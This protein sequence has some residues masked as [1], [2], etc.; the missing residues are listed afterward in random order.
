MKP[1]DTAGAHRRKNRSRAGESIDYRVAAIFWSLGVPTG[2][3]KEPVTSRS[4]Q[5]PPVEETVGPE[6]CNVRPA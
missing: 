1:P 6:R 2:S 3:V 4:C 5:P